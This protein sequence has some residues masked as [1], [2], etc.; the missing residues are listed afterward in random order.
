MIGARVR[1]IGLWALMGVV[2][3]ACSDLPMTCNTHELLQPEDYRVAL[4]DSLYTKRHIT[5]D[6]GA[7]SPTWFLIHA[8][9]PAYVLDGI[10]YV[11]REISYAKPQRPLIRRADGESIPLHYVDMKEQFP[12]DASIPVERWL[13]PVETATY[14]KRAGVEYRC[15]PQR[16]FAYKQARELG[17]VSTADLNELAALLIDDRNTYTMLRRMAQT[18][19]FIVD[20]LSDV[21]LLLTVPIWHPLRA[22]YNEHQIKAE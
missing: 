20:A 19:F 6:D 16:E 11:E 21:A 1:K 3:S 5:N 22:W 2:L 12:V 18:P 10:C 7:N 13:Q 14:P 9:R 8:Y 17:E 15:I 4:V